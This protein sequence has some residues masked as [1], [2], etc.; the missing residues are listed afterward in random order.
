MVMAT[1]TSKGQITIP[2]SIRRTLH[3]NSGDKVAFVMHSDGEALLKPVTKSVDEVFGLLHQKGRPA[4]SVDKMDE[5]VKSRFR[6][7]QS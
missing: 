1:V 4:L 5:S 6:D 7:S 2:K 3:L